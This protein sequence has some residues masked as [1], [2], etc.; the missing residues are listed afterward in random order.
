[1]KPKIVSWNVRGLNE[2]EKHVRIRHLIREWK[3]NI[4]CLQETKLKMI[5]RKT[6]RSLWNNIYVDWVDLASSRASGGVV[7]M[8]D[9]RVVEK[10]EE[11]IGR[12]MIV[13]SFK[14]VSDDFLWAFVGVYGPNLNADRRL[15]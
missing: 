7:V 14:S 9:E 10:V 5:S 12:Y 8:W 3:A 4:V 2:V 6:V 13:C 15:L 1:M 11:F